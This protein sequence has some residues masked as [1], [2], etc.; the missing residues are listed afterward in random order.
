MVPAAIWLTRGEHL[1]NL[2][3]HDFEWFCQELLDFEVS[4]RHVNGRVGGGA[5][6]YVGDD[7]MDLAV[8]ITESPRIPRTEFPHALTLDEPGTTCVS[9]KG[10]AN[11][12]ALLKRDAPRNQR[13]V[14]TLAAGGRF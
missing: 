3:G 4:H 2:E 14:D 6:Q 12:R 8:V 10:A 7:G 5:G 11:W 9:C 13:P 1:R